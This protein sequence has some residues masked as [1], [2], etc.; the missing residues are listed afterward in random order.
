LHNVT[1]LPGW[2][3]GQL[4]EVLQQGWF[5]RPGT[6]ERVE[7]DVRV[8]ATT[9]KSLQG[10]VARGEVLQELF[11]F[12]SIMPIVIPPLRHRRED[13]RPLVEHFV[14]EMPNLR[15]TSPDS[16]RVRFSKEAMN[17]LLDYHWPG[18]VRE[19]ANV[20]QRSAILATGDEIAVANFSE[21]PVEKRE[22]SDSNSITVPLSGDL[23]IIERHII[24]EVIK[25]CQ[26]NKAAAARQ[27]GLHRKTLYRLLEAP[28]SLNGPGSASLVE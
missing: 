26:G 23:K 1:E 28:T 11:Y 7:I 6:N 18:N 2:L 10:A 14:D 3:Q 20:V 9:S 12:L 13:I 4:L 19:L 8:I 25:R 5:T 21:P 16:T 24:N 22:A 15:K 17:C 27:L